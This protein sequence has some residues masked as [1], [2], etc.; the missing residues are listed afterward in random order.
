MKTIIDK[1]IKIKTFLEMEKNNEI[2]I[3]D[4]REKYEH[5]LGSIPNAHHIPMDLILKSISSLEKVKMWLFSV[6]VEEDLLQ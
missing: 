4:I 3:I 1:N 2:Q 6:E 5:D